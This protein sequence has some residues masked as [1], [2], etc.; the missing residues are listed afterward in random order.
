MIKEIRLTQGK[1]ALIDD[2][3]YLFISKIKWHYD[4]GYAVNKGKSKLYMHRL[5]LNAPAGK[6]VDHIN[7]N[8]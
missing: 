6:D 7:G 4:N 1:I 3:D 2:E 5:I 8:G